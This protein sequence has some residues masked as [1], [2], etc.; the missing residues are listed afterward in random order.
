MMI[1]RIPAVLLFLALGA[2]AAPAVEPLQVTVQES[3][4]DVWAPPIINPHKGTIWHI[5][6]TATVSWN[7]S[8]RPMQVTNPTGTLLLG[9][10]RSDGEGGENLDVDHPLAQ[11]FPLNAG[12]VKFVVPRVK[13][14]HNYIVALIGD[15]GNISPKFTIEK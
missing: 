15:S 2:S 1:F 8:T 7:T 14:R 10:L 3:K 6:S 11:G 9:Y 4:R 5:G 12:K 13:P